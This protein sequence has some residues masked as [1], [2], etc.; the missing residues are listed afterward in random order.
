[1]SVPIHVIAPFMAN[2]D[3]EAFQKCLILNKEFNSYATEHTLKF[4]KAAF[5]KRHP[6]FWKCIKRRITRI[7]DFKGIDIKVLMDVLDAL[8]IIK[9]RKKGDK[10]QHLLSPL[11]DR[12]LFTEYAFAKDQDIEI[13][14]QTVNII[15]ELAEYAKDF[16]ADVV[17]PKKWVFYAVMDYCFHGIKELRDSNLLFSHLKFHEQI[18]NRVNGVVPV[19]FK[20]MPKYLRSK[21]RSKIDEIKMGLS[22]VA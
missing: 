7:E 2:N 19:D 22:G 12:S 3:M 15:L 6:L 10:Y 16:K 9:S 5:L 14:V 8:K 1:M 21:I 18:L 4:V 11:L 13:T 17:S 20:H